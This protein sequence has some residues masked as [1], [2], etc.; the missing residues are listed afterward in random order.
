MAVPVTFRDKAGRL[1]TIPTDVSVA[2]NIADRQTYSNER[3]NR[4]IYMPEEPAAMMFIGPRGQG[5][6]TAM[7][8]MLEMLDYDAVY[9]FSPSIDQGKF[10]E[11][12]QRIALAEKEL[13]ATV[14]VAFFDSLDLIWSGHFIRSLD[15]S[16]H[17][18]V[19]L[20]DWVADEGAK[21]LAFAQLVL[22]GRP[23]GVTAL[24]STQTFTGLEKKIRDNATHLLF[25][26]NIPPQDIL[27]IARSYVGELT[28]HRFLELYNE[29]CQLPGKPFFMYDKMTA[30]EPF[31]FR[32][33]F[34]G[35]LTNQW[36][37]RTFVYTYLKKEPYFFL[38]LSFRNVVPTYIFFSI[39]PSGT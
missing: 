26:K 36:T 31:R 18:V 3:W 14:P 7:L 19:I 27:R 22:N 24:I 30:T 12:A 21:K 25:F 17:N 1:T 8:A 15:P 6:T 5:K 2:E 10:R 33:N 9:I 35:L 16:I 23:K 28:P 11:L 13:D 39:S 20:D 29:V 32:A 34:D 37:W 38:Y 4:N